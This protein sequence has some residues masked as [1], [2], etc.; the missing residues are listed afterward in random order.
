MTRQDL[1]EVNANLV[2]SFAEGVAKNCPNAMV[3]VISN[4]V[5]STVPI[6]AEV[7]I[8]SFECAFRFSF[9]LSLLFCSYT[10]FNE[11]V[12]VGCG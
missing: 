7:Q 3:A 11:H 10:P 1:F 9:W 5:N 4:P 8:T 12:L 6:F 2:A